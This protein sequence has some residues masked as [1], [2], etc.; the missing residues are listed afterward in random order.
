MKGERTRGQEQPYERLLNDGAQLAG[1]SADGYILF[2]FFL[3]WLFG[4]LLVLDEIFGGI[5][6][7]VYWVVFFGAI[8]MSP[9]SLAWAGPTSERYSRRGPTQ[10]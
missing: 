6:Q 10:T 1:Y 9:I 4:P 8:V 5:W 7:W 3:M 2:G